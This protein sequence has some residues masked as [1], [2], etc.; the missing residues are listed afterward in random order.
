MFIIKHNLISKITLSN[1]VG[2]FLRGF[3]TRSKNQFHGQVDT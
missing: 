1:K 2:N 3:Q